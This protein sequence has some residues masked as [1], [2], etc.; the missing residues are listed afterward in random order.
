LIVLVVTLV[1]FK[2]LP[3]KPAREPFAISR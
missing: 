1:V 3:L 2:F